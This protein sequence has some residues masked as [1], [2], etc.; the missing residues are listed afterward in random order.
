[1]FKPLEIFVGLRYIRAKRRN[2]FIS[3]IS[4]TS[5]FGIALGVTALITVLSVMNGF[6]TELRDRILGMASHITVSGYE[7]QMTNWSDLAATI[8]KDYPEVVGVAPYVDG[9]GML[10]AG[11][12]VHPSLIRGVSP[13]L[14][15]KVSDVWQHM[16]VG[17]F[18]EL[19]EGKYNIILG[20]TLATVLGVAIGDKVTLVTPQAISTPAGIMPRLKRFTVSGIFEVGHNEYDSSVAFIH[21]EDAAK[22]Y[23]L[24]G[25]VTG[26]RLKLKDLFQA[27]EMRSKL[28]GSLSG[29]YWIRDWTQQHAN[30]FRAVE[31]EKLMMGIML[32]LIVM[33]AVF[34]IVATLVMVVREKQSDIAIMRTLGLSSRSVMGIFIVQ[35]TI[36][37]AFGTLLGLIGGVSLATNIGAV[38]SRIEDWFGIQLMPPDVYYIS[39]FPSELHWVD[40]FVI[41]T[42][43]F[44]LSVLATLYPA[45]SASR[46]QPAEALR[47]E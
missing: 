27:R 4:F 28:V 19:V 45:W 46:T 21:L 22:L 16:Q 23:R 47:Y 11:N 38:I 40:V 35:G 10:S 14:E 26:L 20:A 34:N 39:T 25:N 42:I 32:M 3:F 30:F 33:V 29:S 15:P 9:Q 6:V 7:G 13:E 24:E 36:V 8:H 1:M 12:Q 37:G 2:Q 43:A 17:D 18:N 31:L 44:I 5:T 41:T